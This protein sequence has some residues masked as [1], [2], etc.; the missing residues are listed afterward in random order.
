[1]RKLSPDE[2]IVENH[3]MKQAKAKGFWC[4]KLAILGGSGW[5]DHTI[6]GRGGRIGFVEYKKPVG[7]YQPLQKYILGKLKEFGFPTAVCL[8]KD[9]ADKFL[10]EF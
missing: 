3:F 2:K 1:M 8:T 7:S 6:M 5:P 10:E 4:L 9:E